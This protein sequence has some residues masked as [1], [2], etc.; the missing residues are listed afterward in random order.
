MFENQNLGISIPGDNKSDIPLCVFSQTS[1]P[2]TPL[3]SSSQVSQSG[4]IPDKIEN[5]ST[6]EELVKPGSTERISG[7]LDSVYLGILLASKAVCFY[8]VCLFLSSLI[9]NI[10]P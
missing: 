4:N 6:E 1:P 2:T 9:I 10:A 7:K 8:I 5:G 3:S